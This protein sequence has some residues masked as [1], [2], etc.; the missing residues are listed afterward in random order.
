MTIDVNETAW[1]ILETLHEHGPLN[2]NQ[3]QANTKKINRITMYK[4]FP[5]L[6]KDGY[7]QRD[8]NK[9]Y[10]LNT[11]KY[12]EGK[13]AIQTYVLYCNLS[14]NTSKIFDDLEK[15]AHTHKRVLTSF[16]HENVNIAKEVL[17]SRDFVNLINAT[18]KIFQ[19]GTVM[20]FLINTGIFSKTVEKEAAR[21]RRK[22]ED[23]C[24]KYL[25]TLQKIEPVLWGEIV[26]LIET[27]LASKIDY[28]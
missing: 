22:N 20:E 9:I 23:M 6:K 7:I 4:A 3:I 8:K 15:L 5:L 12:L 1:C 17:R 18:V 19:L 16:S 27:R 25:K 11:A 21:L 10:S 26:M 24:S 28:S 13:K 2:A 14:E